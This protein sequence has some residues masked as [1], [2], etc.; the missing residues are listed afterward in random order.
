MYVF[1]R[2]SESKTILKTRRERVPPLS[3]WPPSAG[4]PPPEG[5]ARWF[6]VPKLCFFRKGE[7]MCLFSYFLGFLPP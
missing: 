6:L 3:P 1:Q 5:W 4:R 7:Q 2:A